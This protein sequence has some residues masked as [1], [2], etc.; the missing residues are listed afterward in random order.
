[1]LLAIDF[2]NTRI[3]SYV[4]NSHALVDFFSCDENN[5]KSE[6]NQIL[7]NYSQITAIISCSVLHTDNTFFKNIS[8]HIL[9]KTIDRQWLFPFKNEYKTPN[10]LGIDRLVLAAGATY[11]FPNQNR[12]IIDIGTCI[13]YDFIDLKNT[14]YGGAISPGISLRYKSLNAHTKK[15]PLLSLKIPDFYIGNTTNES[16]HSGIINGIEYEID[17]FIEQYKTEFGSLTVILT[18]GD[19]EILAKRLKN[20]IFADAIFL[21]KSLQAIYHNNKTNDKKDH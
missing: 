21:A 13:T 8:K 2:G 3:K 10:T 19:C 15:L 14:Y 18:G 9:I 5:F 17:G 11:L 16:I 1:M 6:L 4:F 7:I 20:S 12:L